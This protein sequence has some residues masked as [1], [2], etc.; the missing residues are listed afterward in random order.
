[1]PSS[2]L[3]CLL[4]DRRE[5]TA[6]SKLTIINTVEREQKVC[7]GF[8][9]RHG[10]PL[11]HSLF[12]KAVHTSCYKL[13]LLHLKPLSNTS[14]SDRYEFIPD[15]NR[16]MPMIKYECS[17]VCSSIVTERNSLYSHEQ[18][19][20]NEDLNVDLP[21]RDNGYFVSSHGDNEQPT[22]FTDKN[23]S[24]NDDVHICPVIILTPE[25]SKPIDHNDHDESNNLQQISIH[26][27]TPTTSS[28]N[29]PTINCTSETCITS[30]D[31]CQHSRFRRK[32]KNNMRNRKMIQFR[33]N[34]NA[35]SS[36]RSVRIKSTFKSATPNPQT[37]DMSR[38]FSTAFDEL[39]S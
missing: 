28:S 34:H 39:C 30:T 14:R 27:D 12:N 37:T 35:S 11:N 17:P 10:K 29:T 36:R 38:L 2:V 31:S 20:A 26:L 32:R 23:N 4:Y 25:R 6:K 9:N 3:H 19:C 21:I 24:N 1:M 15:D 5:R 8:K 16:C 7:E 22:Y 18:V 13:I 33:Q